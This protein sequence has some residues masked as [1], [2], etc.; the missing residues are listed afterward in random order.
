[1]QTSK[2]AVPE[3]G[4]VDVRGMTRSAF[5]LRGA[6]AAGAVCG[7][8]AVGPFVGAAMAQASGDIEVLNFALALEHLEATFYK[9][10][11]KELE[12]DLDT[13]VKELAE[14]IEKNEAEHVDTLTQTVEQLGGKPAATP[15]FDFGDAFASQDAFLDLAL[16]FENTGVSAYNGAAAQI[17]S[18][19]VLAAAGA[20]VQVEARHAALVAGHIGEEVTPDGAFEKSL[21]RERVEQAVRPFETS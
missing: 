3:L 18:K 11:V 7:G 12:K 2:L 21:S 16:I 10:G 6:L 9:E 15:R 20:I 13:K 5:I 1:M 17:R 4:A 19:E 14:E 8:A